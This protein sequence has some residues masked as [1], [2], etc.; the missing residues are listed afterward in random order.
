[1]LRDV[2][3]V[4]NNHNQTIK[5]G[6]QVAFVTERFLKVDQINETVEIKGGV[7]KVL[8]VTRIC[9]TG[10]GFAEADPTYELC[11]ENGNWIDCCEAVLTSDYQ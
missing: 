3:E 4:R 2:P 9:Q 11:L 5:V 7:M 1:M 6:D 8:K 10:E